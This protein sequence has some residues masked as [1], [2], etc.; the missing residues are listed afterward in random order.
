MLRTKEQDSKYENLQ[1]LKQTQDNYIF[2][3]NLL[4]II[5]GH[6]VVVFC[7]YEWKIFRIKVQVFMHENS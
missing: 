6:F 1:K 2:H 7:Q 3:R 4:H 5:F